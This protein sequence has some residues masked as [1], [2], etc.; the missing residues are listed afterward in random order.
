MRFLFIFVSLWMAAA[1]AATIQSYHLAQE[2]VPPKPGLAGNGITDIQASEGVIWF[3]TGHGLSRTTDFGETFE[4]FGT[5]HGMARGS[6]SALWVSGDTIWVASAG[7]TLTKVSDSYLT[8]GTGLSVSIDG[9]ATW[10]K[11]PQPGTTPVQNVTYDIA[12]LDGVVWITSF[13]GGLQKSEDWGETW[14]QVP[15]DSFVFDPGGRLNHRAFAVIA[16]DGELWVG[17]AGGIN[18]SSDGGKSWTNFNATNQ[19]HPIS[20]N[21]I[22]ALGH[23]K[24]EKKNIIWAA[25]WKAEGE[26]E[27]YAVSRTENGGLTWQT[28][29][30]G[31]KAHNFAFDDSIVYVATDNGLFK[32]PDYGESWYL[33]PKITDTVTGTRVLTRETYSAYADNGVLWIGTADGLARTRDNGYTWDVFRAFVATG[34]G[35]AP[36]TYAYPNPFSPLRHN[37]LDDEGFVRI[38][39][40]TLAPT[41]VTIKIFDFAMDLVTT[42]VE[43][44]SM[45]GPGDFSE[46]WNGRNDYGDPVANGVY[47][48]SVEL[49]GDGTYWGKIMIVN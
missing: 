10:Q 14:V 41:K 49:D 12:L 43:G 34:Q 30:E 15:P 36:R 31:E 16:A 7:D 9:G 24:T 6:V 46:V 20:G 48:Y 25:T 23:Q 47:F 28:V 8:M 17:T 18:K 38:Q 32:S 5:H 39:Y 35:G 13:G 11:F 37:L 44:K 33:F 2:G 21:F 19:E 3:G 1:S 27:F 26:D 4:S 42:L 22:V 29:L 40:N 45:P